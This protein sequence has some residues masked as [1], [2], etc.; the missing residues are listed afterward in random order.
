MAE[1]RE[2]AFVRIGKFLH[3][4]QLLPEEEAV[5]E[6]EHFKIPTVFSH[7]EAAELNRA[8]IKHVTPQQMIEILKHMLMVLKP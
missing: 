1:T 6:I 4:L 7:T 2:E 5:N 3:R 8:L